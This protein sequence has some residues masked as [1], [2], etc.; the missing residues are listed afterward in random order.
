M[1]LAQP[2]SGIQ[3][4][5]TLRGYTDCRLKRCARAALVAAID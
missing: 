1:Q 2:L 3:S 5:G 4:A